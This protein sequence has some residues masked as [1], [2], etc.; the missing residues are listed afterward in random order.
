MVITPV[1]ARRMNA[2]VDASWGARLRKIWLALMVAELDSFSDA[3]AALGV[4]QSAA[5]RSIQSLELELQCALFARRGHSVKATREGE[6]LLLR[7]KRAHEQL[8]RAASD[9]A[10]T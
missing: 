3:A 2:I 7:A 8:R 1:P 6:I 9:L 4:S 10:E 5:S